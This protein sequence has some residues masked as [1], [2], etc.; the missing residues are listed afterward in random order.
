MKLFVVLV[1]LCSIR[2]NSATKELIIACKCNYED[3]EARQKMVM[4]ADQQGSLSC[5]QVANG[6]KA[7]C[8]VSE[9]GS[10]YCRQKDN[11]RKEDFKACCRAIGRFP[12]CY[13]DDGSSWDIKYV[14]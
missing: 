8:D 6:P 7:T 9:I 12:L 14:R 2:L 5:Q 4:R 11:E 10:R 3:G 1:I 13:E